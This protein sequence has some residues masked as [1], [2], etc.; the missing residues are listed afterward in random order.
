MLVEAYESIEMGTELE[1]PRTAVRT[2]TRIIDYCNTAEEPRT[3]HRMEGG[4]LRNERMVWPDTAG[5][6]KRG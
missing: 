2:R 6:T 5:W 1:N 4:I 3:A